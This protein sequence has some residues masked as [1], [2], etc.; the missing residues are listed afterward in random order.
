MTQFNKG[1]Y[2]GSNNV[3]DDLAVIGGFLPLL[4]TS[5]GSSQATAAP[6]AA[7]V[8]AATGAATANVQGVVA[9][10]AG[11][12]YSFQAAAGT[13]TLSAAVVAPWSGASNRANLDIQLVVYD[14]D[15]TALATLNPA[16]ADAASLGVPATPVTLPASGT[17]I[18]A[19]TGA[20]AGDVASSGYSSYGSRGQFEL[21]AVYAP[22]TTCNDTPRQASPSPAPVQPSPSP[23]PEPSPSPAP[24][25]SPSPAPLPSPSPLPSPPPAQPQAMRVTNIIMTKVPQGKNRFFC[26]VTIYVRD[27]AGNPVSGVRVNGAFSARPVLTTFASA[28][29]SQLTAASTGTVAFRSANTVP[30]SPVYT[31][32]FSIGD[33]SLAGYF[34]DA[35][36]SVLTRTAVMA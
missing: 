21:T 31:C 19:V 23:A 8:D 26:S 25:P 27:A 5:A 12:W 35:I 14:A 2:A 6:L 4:A 10:A 34:F 1:E 3:Q 9:S 20:G 36:N 32:V 15:G 28:T 24:M 30:K 13:V 11:A 17:Y 29:S 33:V 7:T 22:C 16:G 18:V